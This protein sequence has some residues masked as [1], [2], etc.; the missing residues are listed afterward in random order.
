MSFLWHSQVHSIINSFGDA[1]CLFHLFMSRTFS[2]ACCA[3]ITN[4]LSYTIAITAHLLNHEWALS[5]SL[6]SSTSA[7]PTL[8]TSGSWLCLASFTCAA[9][10]CSAELHGWLGSIYSI[11]K[12]NFYSQHNVFSTLRC[13]LLTSLS[14]SLTT[15]TKELLKLFKNVSE[16]RASLLPTLSELVMK[17]FETRK[18]TKS[19]AKAS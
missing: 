8:W 18:T 5:D 16:R 7:C 15:S 17:P 10:V 9:Q 3:G 6:E 11:H 13:C 14:S 12:V 19:L 1:Y 2:T 4:H